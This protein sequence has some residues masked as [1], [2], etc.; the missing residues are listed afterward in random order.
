[1]VA[2]PARVLLL[3]GTTEAAALATLLANRPD[4]EVVA[5]L[6]G[7][8]TTPAPLPCEVRTGGF[9]GPDGLAHALRDGGFHAL[10]DA[11]HPFAGVMPHHA[12]AAASAAG[13]PRV[14][15]VRP[16][17]RPAAGDRW[18]DVDDLT[19][20]AAALARVGARRVFLTT[21]RLELAPFA[22]VP[23]VHFVVRSI[24]PPDP[25]PWPAAVSTVV[26]ARG[27]F[28]VDDELALLRAHRIDTI[29]TRNSGGDATA[30][31]LTAARALG[32]RVVMVRR[33][34]PPPGPLAATPEA[35]LRWLDGL[36]ARR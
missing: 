16:P 19:A 35:A 9:G 33:P 25:V 7:R 1:V 31:K 27:P 34:A 4:L 29:V 18:H 23:G 21:G 15:L 24:E 8:T 5:S 28:T 12:A 11:T 6:A 26:L 32:T 36:P 13:V 14:R 3:A 30:A 20:A 17:W 2:G 22:T 10:V